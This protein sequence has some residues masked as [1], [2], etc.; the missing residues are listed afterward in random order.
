MKILP[1][2]LMF[3][4]L[5]KPRIIRALN[6][7]LQIPQRSLSLRIASTRMT[8]YKN[9]NT[10]ENNSVTDDLLLL[11]RNINKGLIARLKR[12]K[13]TQCGGKD[14]TKQYRELVEDHQQCAKKPR[15]WR[16]D[17][18]QISES[19]RRTGEE[20]SNQRECYQSTESPNCLNKPERYND[21][22]ACESAKHESCESQQATRITS[23]QWTCGKPATESEI[24][25]K[26]M[27]EPCTNSQ[28]REEA[29][30]CPASQDCCTDRS[31][32]I[33]THPTQLCP[34]SEPVKM[35]PNEICPVEYKMSEKYPAPD[36][37]ECFRPDP[38]PPRYEHW[39]EN[40]P[41]YCDNC[42]RKMARSTPV[43]ASPMIFIPKKGP[44]RRS[45]VKD[46]ALSPQKI[47]DQSCKIP[48]ENACGE[49]DVKAPQKIV[50]RK[51]CRTSFEDKCSPSLTVPRPVK[52]MESEIRQ[53][54]MLTKDGRCCVEKPEKR[55]VTSSVSDCNP[56]MES[57]KYRLSKCPSVKEMW[58]T[59]V[60]ADPPVDDSVGQGALLSSC[61]K[62]K[63]Q[64][65]QVENTSSKKRRFESPTN[66]WM[67]QKY[68]IRLKIFQKENTHLEPGLPQIVELRHQRD[69]QMRPKLLKSAPCK[70]ESSSRPRKLCPHKPSE[71]PI[72]ETKSY[73]TKMNESRVIRKH[74]GKYSCKKNC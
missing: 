73:P 12:G 64:V 25:Y 40:P 2:I 54:P 5:K 38:P 18:Y 57:F 41:S 66:G 35:M 51:R 1:R 14:D 37:D 67:R 17:G 72:A 43:K 56:N 58:G 13:N 33:E 30:C 62:A 32:Q 24:Y 55:S 60:K 4:S 27:P 61:K 21:G 71:M 9:F 53:F 28:N 46:S 7:S 15:E 22:R 3:L 44:W 34:E 10:K 68:K 26:C 16:S 70:G 45:R 6:A 48:D 59:G 19:C 31:K 49:T 36:T 23:Q 42:C 65:S 11:Q 20:L 74:G 8:S 50:S 63:R 52:T 39:R 69:E 29:P 47:H